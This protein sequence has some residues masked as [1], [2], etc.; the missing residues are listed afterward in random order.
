[1]PANGKQFAV[2]SP[3][4]NG[5]T[6]QILDRVFGKYST[7]WLATKSAVNKTE[8]TSPFTCQVV[9]KYSANRLITCV[10]ST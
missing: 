3:I 8:M 7:I 9:P 2:T 1:M 5:T 4:N 10:S 6:I